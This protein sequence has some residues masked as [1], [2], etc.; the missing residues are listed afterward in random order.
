MRHQR[1]CAR[2]AMARAPFELDAKTVRYIFVQLI[3]LSTQ[4]IPGRRARASA[5]VLFLS[6]EIF[7][8]PLELDRTA[9]TDADAM[10]DHQVGKVASI[11]Q[12]DPV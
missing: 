10:L 6:E 11:D 1:Q 8:Q 5:N 7:V 9:E 12:D 3:S 2:R 4:R